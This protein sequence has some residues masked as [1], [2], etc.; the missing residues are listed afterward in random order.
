MEIK[1]KK[2]KLKQHYESSSSTI[3]DFN[4]KSDYFKRK[5]L[6][7]NINKDIFK[8]IEIEIVTLED[9]I[10]D[11]K[12]QKIDLIKIDT[13]GYEFEVLSGLR[14][15]LSSV[16]FL[17]FE[18]H[19]DDML[20]KSYTFRDI[21]NLLKKY[22]FKKILKLKMPFRKSFEYIYINEKKC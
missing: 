12:F 6:L 15:K 22:N 2:K 17:M 3:N 4:E 16:K 10:K 13:E 14:D 21:S 7:L 9:Y 18:H 5:N 20:L 19:Y 8:E 1:K 11:N